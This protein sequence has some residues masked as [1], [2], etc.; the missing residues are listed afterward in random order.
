MADG[1]VILFKA[2]KG[3]GFIKPAEDGAN[4]YVHA[5]ALNNIDI[6]TFVIGT[7][8]QYDVMTEDGKTS[9]INVTIK[10]A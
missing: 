2:D 5:S 9:A 8:V 6:T 1:T 7:N 3:Y 10:S 4:I